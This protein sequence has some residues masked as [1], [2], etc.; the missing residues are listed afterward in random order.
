MVGASF[1]MTVDG[2]MMG[3]FGLVLRTFL[4]VS[5]RCPFAVGIDFGRCLWMSVLVRPGHVAKKDLSIAWV[6]VWTTGL[7]AQRWSHVA[8]STFVRMSC[9]LLMVLGVDMGQRWG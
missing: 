3:F 8:R 4:R 9:T 5:L 2:V 1:V 7:N 6:Q